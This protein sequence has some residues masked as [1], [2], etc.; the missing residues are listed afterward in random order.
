MELSRNF[1]FLA[2]HDQEL[3]VLG[4]FAERYYAEDPNTCSIKLRQYAELLAQL[5]A[6]HE[7]I[8]VYHVQKQ[9][10]LLRE[11]R[12]EG[13]PQQALDLFHWLRKDGNDA[14]HQRVSNQQLAL[15]HLRYAYRLGIWF[16]QT[17]GDRTFKPQPFVPP[18]IKT[19]DA[20]LKEQ[21]DQL[22]RIAKVNKQTAE[23]AKAVAAEE[24]K[25][26]ETAEQHAKDLAEKLKALQAAA[27]NQTAQQRQDTR[28]RS[29]TVAA[30][31][32]LTEQDARQLIDQQLQAVGW[33]ADTETLRYSKGARPTV[34]RNMAIAEYPLADN[35]RV[36]YA[37]FVGTK[38][39]GIL[40]A[41]AEDAA[42][43]QA[44]TS[45]YAKDIAGSY[46]VYPFAFFSDYYTTYFWDMGRGN[47]R[48]VSGVFGPDDLERLAHIRTHQSPLASV[49]PNTSIVDRTYQLEAIQ[50]IGE[51]FE[52]GKRRALLVM[53]TGT[54]KTR[55][56]MALIE[57]FL[58]TGQALKVLF[59]ADRDA[60]VSQAMEKGFQQHLPDE[61]RT[62]IFTKSIDKTKRLYVSTQQTLDR[63]YQDF[64]PGFFDLIIFD[65]AHRSLFNKFAEVVDYFD[66]RMIGLTAT[67]ASFINRNTFQLFHCEG[68]TPTF[69]YPYRQAVQEKYLVDFSLYLAQTRFQRQGI[70]GV[71]LSEDERDV[72]I[73][74][75][76]D[77]D[78]LDFTGSDLEKKV[79]NKDTLRKQWEEIMEVCFK[80][81]SGQLPAKTI[82]FAMTQAHAKRLCDTF[83]EMYPHWQDLVKVITHKYE[84]NGTLVKQFTKEDKPRIAISVD[85]LDTGV[86]VPE[87]MNL[88]FMKPVQS[89]I[90]LWQMIGRGTRCQAACDHLEWLPNRQKNEFKIIDFWENEFDQEERQS[91]VQ[92]LPI[93]VRLFNTR[94]KLMKAMLGQQTSDDFQ[95]LVQDVRGQ[96]GLIPT[97]A[98][99]VKKEWHGIKQAWSDRFWRRLSD[100]DLTFLQMNVAPLLRFAAGVNL[101]EATFIHKIERLKVQQV[102]DKV[103]PALIES[104]ADD[105]AKLPDYVHESD[106]YRSVLD[107]CTSGQVGTATF[108]ELAEITEL[109]AS[110]MKNKRRTRS[111]LVELDLIDMMDVQEYVL[112]NDGKEQVYVADYRERVES[113]VLAVVSDHPVLQALENGEA[114]SDFQLVSL[115]RTLRKELD[116]YPLELSTDNIR[117]AYKIKVGSFLEFARHLLDLEG[118]PDYEV[119]VRRGFEQ[120]I[121]EHQFR[122]DQIRFLRAVESIFMQK[123]QL[124]VADLYE[125]PL[126][127]FGQDAVDRLFTD[128][129]VNELMAFTQDIA[130]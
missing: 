7:R 3:A 57:R 20:E 114:V 130:V 92:D 90:K 63:C 96:I 24:A 43:A 61:P 62:R 26:R 82:V 115:E 1:S 85:M 28:Q 72:L 42:K 108:A 49:Q 33:E 98:F 39:L 54:G 123:R 75:G 52:A 12:R 32:E 53:A 76:K 15:N 83:E 128:E 13:V 9:H 87:A 11:L 73:E 93:L 101:A 126:V 77:P 55:T 17:Y 10:E 45:V 104:I 67:P 103:S 124:D 38:L 5:T 129:Q 86:D 66:A 27:A 74:Q 117:K 29:Q 116:G 48:L 112:L 64:S 65:E 19:V 100:R 106:R 51:A 31:I 50:R 35:R 14:V 99:S 36:D 46:S 4:S 56:A 69:L 102:Q 71:D 110:Q 68:I 125:G 30:A 120:F 34:G 89:A 2:S 118:L 25:R 127:R 59:V 78:E 122:A 44:Q 91:E 81:E 107:K 84:Y 94:I 119:L 47:K 18:P 41:K 113:T 111:T 70:S 80:D 22:R 97:D 6:A 21:I 37:L 79:T 95:R 121:A 109:L 8:A 105:V 58:Q 40:E 88:V 16:H 60:L 23:S